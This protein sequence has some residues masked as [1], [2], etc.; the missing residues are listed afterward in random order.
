MAELKG[1]ELERVV[2]FEEATG[3]EVQTCDL[4]Y[5]VPDMAFIEFSDTLLSSWEEVRDLRRLWRAWEAWEAEK[6]AF[7]RKYR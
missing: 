5:G 3:V 6:L 7:D 4:K 1:A 2:R